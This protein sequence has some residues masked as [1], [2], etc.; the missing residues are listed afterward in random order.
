MGRPCPD[1]HGRADQRVRFRAP[2]GN[3]TGT[4]RAVAD[5]R[6]RT[7]RQLSKLRDQLPTQG[8]LTVVGDAMR[9][10]V[11]GMAESVTRQRSFPE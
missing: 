1:R 2:A 3:G 5:R 7:T 6:G 9:F 8:V 11:P 10:S 4:G